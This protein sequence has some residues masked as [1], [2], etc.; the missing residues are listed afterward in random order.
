MVVAL[1]P[2]HRAVGIERIVVSTYQAASGA[3]QA[4][5]DEMIAHT[6]ETLEGRAPERS[7]KFA[8][9]VA[10]NCLPHIDVF[11]DN[12]YTREEMKMVH[13]TRKILGDET[14]RVTATCV[15]VPVMRSHSEAINI[16]TREKMTADEA[17]RLLAGAPGVV[18]LDDP[19]AKVYPMPR[20]AAHRDAVYVGRI[21]EDESIERGLNLWV[22]ADQLLKGAALNAVQIAEIL[23]ARDRL[24]VRV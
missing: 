20:E 14:I 11:M 22:V 2:I 17:R 8:H 16:Q 23:L 4:A 12:G 6:R 19:G 3:G 24:S 7:E 1:A 15:R 13:E 9:P 18:V 5:M 21:R 10:F